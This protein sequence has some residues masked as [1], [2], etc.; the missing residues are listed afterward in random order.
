MQMVESKKIEI[1][2]SYI[3]SRI[4]GLKKY[5]L[6]NMWETF[7]HCIGSPCQPLGEPISKCPM[8]DNSSFLVY[9]DEFFQAGV[10]CVCCG[11]AHVRSGIAK[12]LVERDDAIHRRFFRNSIPCSMF[13]DVKAGGKP[14]SIYKDPFMIDPIEM[15]TF[16]GLHHEW[17]LNNITM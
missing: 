12:I 7:Y 17:N 3:H 1:G 15:I 11:F 13:F 10:G 4:S 8:C 14:F 16:R 5:S 9:V 2:N 6:P